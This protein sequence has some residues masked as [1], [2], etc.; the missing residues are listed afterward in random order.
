MAALSA[1]A[2]P[3]LA[4]QTPAAAQPSG[5]ATVQE[6]VVTAQRQAQSLLS[7]PMSIAAS[8]GDQLER[9]GI[10][11]LSQLQFT[12]PGYVPSYSSGYTQLYI[13]GIGN[14]IFV[15]ADPSVATFVDDV[16]RIYGSMVENFVDVERIEVLKGAQGGL[17]GRNATGGVVNI[18]THQ[19]STDSFHGEARVSY[20]EKATARAAAF[21]NMPIND[22]MA[23]SLAFDRETHDP[24]VENIARRNPYTASMFTAPS[25]FGS[26]EATAATLNSAVQPS[27]GYADQDFWAFNAKLLVKP[28]DNLKVTFSGD[29]ARK[30]DSNG[31]QI[32]AGEPGYVQGFATGFFEGFGFVD[33]AGNP[34]VNFPAGFFR[35]HDGDFTLEKALPAFTDLTDYGGSM[36]AVWSL[37][38][39]DL[40][41]I[42][43]YRAQQT[44][45]FE[46]L[47][48]SPV[49]LID[50]LV[51][52]RKWFLYQELRAVSTDTGRWHYLAGAT[53]LSNNFHGWNHTRYLGLITNPSTHVV[54]AVRNWSIYAQLGYDITDNLNL[55]VS[56]R[57]VDET[58]EANFSDP[59]VSSASMKETKFLPSATLSYKLDGGGN[60]YARWAKGFK[61]GGVNPIAPPAVFPNLSNGSIF[62]PE[63]VDTYEVGYRA[64]LFDRTVQV[65]LAAFYNDYRD[66]QVAAHS[67]PEHPE[68]FLAIV[69]AGSARTY[70]AEGSVTWRV[71][72]AVT[73]GANVGYLDARYKTF[74]INDPAGILANF[75]VS[76]ERMPNSPRWQLSFSGDLDQPINDQF[77][78]V[79]SMLV[80]HLSSMTFL[81]SA[82]P[83]ILPEPTQEGYWL[84]NMRLG[85]RTTDDKYGLAIFANNLF[86]RGYITYGSSSGLGNQLTWGTPRIVGAEVTAK[87]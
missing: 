83:G 24:Y 70:G 48:A 9:A 44:D 65:T 32:F 80:S 46:D 63:I 51:Q 35:G 10:R 36:T 5:A 52:N 45:F 4:Q 76:G 25:L 43:A 62:R 66:L 81:Q 7:V 71:N 75:D 27:S 16:P 86:N 79:G 87:F 38:H 1:M 22:K 49:P 67:T 47:V 53:Y 18:I 12:T 54:D 15:G 20:G 60:I 61:A 69:N 77:R 31:N 14:N 85:V 6:I 72:R 21:A 39:V 28:A 23:F 55:T 50:V 82:L 3:A 26:P 42:T 8:S 58:N 57:Y 19:P 84:A 33:A 78:L 37:P 59:I 56:G 29:F 41:S 13:R 64:P 11:D 34:T 2:G 68:I 17:Y 73:L 40:T 74:A 30:R